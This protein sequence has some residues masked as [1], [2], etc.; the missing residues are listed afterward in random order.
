MTV[1][2]CFQLIMYGLIVGYE[3]PRMASRF[4]SSKFPETGYPDIPL[5]LR[6]PLRE[7]GLRCNPEKGTR[8]LLI[9]QQKRNTHV[10]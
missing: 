6:E 3:L 7:P 2:K 8:K 4:K 5:G 9:N 10:N 1:S